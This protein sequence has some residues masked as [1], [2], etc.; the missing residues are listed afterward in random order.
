MGETGTSVP[1]R[2]L[3]SS[4]I[5]LVLEGGG[6]KGA[7]SHGFAS[8]CD[9]LGI[10]FAAVSGT[11]VGGLEAWIVA[12]GKYDVGD[13]LWPSLNFTAIYAPRLAPWKAVA[14]ALFLLHAFN[15]WAS[16]LPPSPDRSSRWNH[17]LIAFFRTTVFL[18]LAAIFVSVSG[19]YRY[20]WWITPIIL[21]LIWFSLSPLSELRNRK[22]NAE[23]GHSYGDADDDLSGVA[24]QLLAMLSL[25]LI[26]A[27]IAAMVRIANGTASGFDVAI[28]CY[29]IAILAMRIGAS[30]ANLSDTPLISIIDRCLDA[31][32]HI[33]CF[34][35][36][37]TQADRFTPDNPKVEAISRD[38]DDIQY[39]V[40]ER[41]VFLPRYHALHRL[42]RDARRT[43]L[44]ATAALPFGLVGSVSYGNEKFV[45]GG[46][47]D[48]LPLLPLIDPA[49]NLD[50]D[51]I[52]IVRLK[53]PAGKETQAAYAEREARRIA[54][55]LALPE[56]VPPVGTSG[57][58]GD[59]IRKA[60]GALPSISTPEL[61]MPRLMV[62]CPEQDLK[63][64]LDFAEGQQKMNQGRQ[65]AVKFRDEL[66]GLH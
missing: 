17:V 62:I 2:R 38:V 57:S 50:L 14:V 24:C 63:G 19:L 7:F 46:M 9:K 65:A 15:L 40:I 18:P 44:R 30:Q 60:C 20:P 23:D 47:A 11:S 43:L 26:V 16:G 42:D 31:P 6:A 28:L 49:H 35:T 53:M 39:R 33:P 45:D 34:V 21:F 48:N 52:V 64:L 10:K 36:T 37:A 66:T 58:K 8:A 3:R 5:G 4:R 61:R 59:I 12:T 41:R 56:R 27:T 1:N 51:L 55:L 32:P 54:N 25:F 22:P 29:F 13:E